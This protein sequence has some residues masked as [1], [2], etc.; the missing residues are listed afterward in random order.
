MSKHAIYGWKARFG[1]M[2]ATD[3]QKLRALEDEN[4]RLK[5]LVADLSLERE[6]LKAVIA[7]TA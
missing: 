1:G 2:E 5:R 7:K 3:V 4:G 6:M